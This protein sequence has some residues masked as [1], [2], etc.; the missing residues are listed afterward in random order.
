MFA[1]ATMVYNFTNVGDHNKLS[2][3]HSKWHLRLLFGYRL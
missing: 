1:G 2:V 3:Y